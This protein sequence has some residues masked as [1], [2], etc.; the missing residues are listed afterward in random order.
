MTKNCV[1]VLKDPDSGIVM[2][3]GKAR[4][5]KQRY[6]SHLRCEKGKTRSAQW[7][8]QL[9]SVGNRPSMEV[10]DECD[11]SDVFTIEQA[12]ITF[13]RYA[14]P[15]LLNTMCPASFICDYYKVPGVPT[16]GDCGRHLNGNDGYVNTSGEFWC[17][18]CFGGIGEKLPPIKWKPLPH[19]TPLVLSRDAYMYATTL[20]KPKGKVKND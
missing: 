7:I 5:A 20:R 19:L 14:N 11:E 6:V 16:C 3:V 15:S 10:I 9:M 18:L 8:R 4:D 13:Y 2:Y 12:W 1:Y 17:N